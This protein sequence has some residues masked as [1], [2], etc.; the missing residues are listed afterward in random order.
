M[1]SK[2]FFQIFIVLLLVFSSV[3]NVQANSDR[4]FDPQDAIVIIA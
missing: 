2:R 1:K 3:G 4:A